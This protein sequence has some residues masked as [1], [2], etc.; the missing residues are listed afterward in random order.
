MIH[1]K[2]YSLP[3]QKNGLWSSELRDLRVGSNFVLKRMLQFT[4]F[5]F[6]V[7]VLKEKLITSILIFK[8]R[9]DPG[10]DAAPAACHAQH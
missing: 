4:W 6:I 10:V 9:K 2:D 3:P 7:F 8:K 1:K 5:F